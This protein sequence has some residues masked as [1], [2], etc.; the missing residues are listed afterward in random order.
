MSGQRHSWASFRAAGAPAQPPLRPAP[1]FSFLEWFVTGGWQCPV[2]SHCL[3]FDDDDR[4]PSSS[5]GVE[6]GGP[7]SFGHS[8]ACLILHWAFHYGSGKHW[9]RCGHASLHLPNEQNKGGENKARQ[10]T[11]FRCLRVCLG[12]F[13]AGCLD[14]GI[15]SVRLHSGFQT[16]S[17]ANA[18]LAQAHGTATYPE[19]PK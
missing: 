11:V 19:T 1:L 16:T 7:R 4:K 13:G 10:L 14:V 5:P 2:P 12:S 8:Q 9:I 3:G 17:V 6:S 18:W 15:F